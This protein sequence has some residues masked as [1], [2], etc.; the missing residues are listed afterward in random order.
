MLR[1]E[2]LPVYVCSLH[3]ESVRGQWANLGLEMLYMTNDDEERHSMQSE[4][5]LLRNLTVQAADPPLGYP[6]YSTEPVRVLTL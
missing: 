5:A 6:V 3:G 1:E 2:P 4:T